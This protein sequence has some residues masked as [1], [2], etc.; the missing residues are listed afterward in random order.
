MT[1]AQRHQAALNDPDAWPLSEED[2]ARMKRKALK[3]L[4]RRIDNS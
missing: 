1:D 2:L 3:F 4:P